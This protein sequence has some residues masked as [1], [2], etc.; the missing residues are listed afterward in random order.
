MHRFAVVVVGLGRRGLHHLAAFRASPR[1]RLVGVADPDPVRLYAAAA[2]A[3][4]AQASSDAEML[5]G[6]TRPDVLCFCT[7]PA[8]RMPL[9]RLGVRWNVPLIAFEKP[10][11]CSM[12][13]AREIRSLLTA[14]GTRAVVCHQHRYGRHYQRVKEIV[15]SGAL[16]QVHTI[17]ATAVGGMLHMMPHLVEYMRWFNDYADAD[18]VLAQTAGRGKLTD[19]HPSPDYIGGFVH[20]RNGVRGVL[21]SGVG[22]P[23]VPEVDH[24]WRKNRIGVLGTD[25]FAEV[26]TGAGWRAVTRTGAWSGSGGMDYDRDMPPYVEDIGEWLDDASRVH[27]CN[28]E[29]AYRTHEIMMALCRSAALGTQVALPLAAGPAE[30][31][32]LGRALSPAPALASCPENAA[33]YPEGRTADVREAH[34]LTVAT[35]APERSTISS[36][37]R[38]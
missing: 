9:I 17:Y 23:D 36:V 3:P 22:A 33:H 13:E 18:W 11:A 24:W 5:L 25:G 27:P 26:L 10:V 29:S 7:P 38:T 2:I 37:A 16:G 32:E 4:E 6:G 14:S 34:P 15:A 20:F 35:G 19:D 28:F 30:P 8:V 31:E 21:E 12:A 1:F